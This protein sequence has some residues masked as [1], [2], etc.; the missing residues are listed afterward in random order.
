MAGLRKPGAGKGQVS[1]RAWQCFEAGTAG[2]AQAASISTQHA[3]LHALV[4]LGLGRRA[5]W[6]CSVPDGRGG[7][8]FPLP[9]YVV[10][11]RKGEYWRQRVGNDFTSLSPICISGGTRVKA[12]HGR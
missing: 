2:R 3:S 4:G 7:V 10:S 11:I 9:F 6:Q 5:A 12:I 1:S 8:F